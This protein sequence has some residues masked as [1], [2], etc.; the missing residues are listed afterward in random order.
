MT[1]GERLKQAR[2][3]KGLSQSE[4]G[5]RINVH[6]TQVGRYENKGAKPAG[7]VLARIANVLEVSSDYLMNGNAETIANDTLQD[8]ELLNHFKQIETLSEQ[9]RNVVKV[10]LDAFIT[11]KQL[12][13]LAN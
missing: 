11:K 2:Q 13:K 9:D 6:Y 8:K 10:F 4:L 3:Q 12:Q 5:K 7:D 1:F